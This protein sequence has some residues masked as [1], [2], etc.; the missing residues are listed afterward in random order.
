MSGQDSARPHRWLLATA[1]LSA[2]ALVLGLAP[3]AFAGTVIMTPS[4]SGSGS[5]SFNSGTLCT[6]GSVANGTVTPCGPAVG[7]TLVS[8]VASPV[9]NA[10][11]AGWQGCPVPSG[12]VCQGIYPGAGTVSYTPVAV[13]VDSTAPSYTVSGG[14]VASAPATATLSWTT[15]EPV[16]TPE[17]QLDSGA[18]GPCS[19]STSHT[20]TAAE[21][22]HT[23]AVRGQDPSGNAGSGT[24]TFRIIETTLVSGPADVSNTASPTFVFASGAGT[25]FACSVDNV[26]LADCGVKDGAG[27]GTK[28]FSGLG[29]GTHTFR[30][31]ATD[32]PVSD[33]STLV[34]SWTIDTVAPTATLDP[35][36]GPNEGAL[37]SATTETFAF[38][39]ED[40]GATF[41]C[42]L[43]SAA[44]AACTSPRTVSGLKPGAH[45]FDVRATDPAG[46]VGPAATRTW[47]VA[48]KPAPQKA[49]LKLAAKAGRRTTTI[50]VLTVQGLGTGAK[51]TLRCQGKG[52]PAKLKGRGVSA[53]ATTSSLALR[54]KVRKPVKAGTT[55]L[56]T[57]RLAG[58]TTSFTVRIRAGA[59]PV[60]TRR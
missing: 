49:T 44:F 26:T 5:I 16:G 38:T 53:T 60:V 52:C 14:Q 37:Q 3:P 8:L 31:R 21:G 56:I 2:L 25:A 57:A 42:R 20:V 36:S 11:F 30:V 7:D 10:T 35:S 39:S 46:N 54:S 18:W 58:W 4:I 1:A 19:S 32:G 15:D 12:T 40:A 9:G 48:G 47:S 22:T 17:C 43:D 13:F 59:K 23:L 24:I 34:R 29:D 50:S 55:L 45:H 51:V 27:H 33:P 28:S 6:S 41:Q